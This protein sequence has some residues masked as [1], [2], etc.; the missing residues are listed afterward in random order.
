MEHTTRVAVV[1]KKTH[2]TIFEVYLA[3]GNFKY[4]NEPLLHANKLIW[5]G[6]MTYKYK[7]RI[8]MSACMSFN[9]TLN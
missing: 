9:N 4:W 3:V 2:K 1:N 6:V 8:Y 7:A 5:V